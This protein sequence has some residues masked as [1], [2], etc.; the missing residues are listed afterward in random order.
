M[1]SWSS[2][3]LR[4]GGALGFASKASPHSCSFPPHPHGS[5][6]LSHSGVYF[7]TGETLPSLCQQQQTSALYWYE[8]QVPRGFPISSLGKMDLA[9][10]LP[11]EAVHLCLVSGGQEGGFHILPSKGD[12]VS[13]HHF[14]LPIRSSRDELFPLCFPRQ[15]KA[16][17][18]NDRNVGEACS[19]FTLS[20]VASN[21]F[22]YTWSTDRYCSL[23]CS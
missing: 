3:D 22:L 9:S 1:F 6:T 8:I 12:G 5:R 21:H 2:L 19:C 10:I 14:P 17:A 18:W 4:R 23:P 20:P 7:W 11:L 13:S 16:F 15:H